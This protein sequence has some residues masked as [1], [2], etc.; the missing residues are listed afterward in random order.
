VLGGNKTNP[1]LRF[2]TNANGKK[3]AKSQKQCK[4]YSQDDNINGFKNLLDC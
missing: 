1:G 3:E 2:L 4:F